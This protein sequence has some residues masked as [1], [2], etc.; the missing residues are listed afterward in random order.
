[1]GQDLWKARFAVAAADGVLREGSIER[2]GY[3]NCFRS[4]PDSI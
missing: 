2:T 4:S 1:M 3:R